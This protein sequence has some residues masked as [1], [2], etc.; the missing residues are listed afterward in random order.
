MSLPQPQNETQEEEPQTGEKEVPISVISENDSIAKV[1]ADEDVS[2][3]VKKFKRRN[4]ELYMD[5][6]SST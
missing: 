4:Q 3:T 1:V 2:I 5:P 6:E